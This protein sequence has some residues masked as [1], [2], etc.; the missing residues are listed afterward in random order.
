MAFSGSIQYG[1]VKIAANTS[2]QQRQT[3]SLWIQYVRRTGLPFECVLNDLV[4]NSINIYLRQFNIHSCWWCNVLSM[5]V[6]MPHSHQYFY[7]HYVLCESLYICC[8]QE[9]VRA[10]R[11]TRTTY[12]HIWVIVCLFSFSVSLHSELWMESVEMRNVTAIMLSIII[13]NYGFIC[14]T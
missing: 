4:E 9:R 13:S 3:T 7:I 12:T 11:C 5:R 8:A 1:Y 14:T 6:S 10:M 2:L